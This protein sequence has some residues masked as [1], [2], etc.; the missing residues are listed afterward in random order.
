[1]TIDVTLPRVVASPHF[2]AIW[3]TGSYTAHGEQLTG[4]TIPARDAVV[5][6]N[7]AA[8]VTGH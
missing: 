3:N 7:E 6:V 8:H 1:V 4:V 2:T 5:L